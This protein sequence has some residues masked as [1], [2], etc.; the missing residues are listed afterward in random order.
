MNFNRRP[1]GTVAGAVA[2]IGSV[3][4]IGLPAAS[5]RAA[6]TTTTV[7]LP[8]STYS[9][10]V[11][12]PAH[13]HIF[14]SSAASNTIL[15]TNYSGQTV[16]TIT[17][18]PGADGLA[19]SSDGA[20]VYAA[21][22]T[23]DAISAIS[24][25][26]LAETARYATGTGTDPTYVAYTSGKVWFGYGTYGD[27]FQN[28]IGSI[29]PSTSPATVNL[30]A[31]NE[32][33]ALWYAAPILA[34][35]PNG[36]LVA[37]ETMVSGALNMVSFDT[38]SGGVATAL[39]YG[40]INGSGVESMQIT[41]DGK[42][43][44][45]ASGSPYY[46]QILQVSDMALVGEYPTAA[47]PVGVSIADDGTVAAGVGNGLSDEV[48]FFAPGGSTPLNTESFG[49]SDTLAADGVAITPDATEL[50]A[51]TTGGANPTLNI[52]TDPVQ[53][54][55]TLSLTAPA[56][57]RKH[58]P[59]T[60][61]GTLGGTSPY[62]GGQPLQVTRIDQAHPGGIALPGVTTAADGSFTITDTPPNFRGDSEKVTYKVSY[63]GDAHLTASTASAS[64]TVK[65]A[66]S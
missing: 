11:L 4:A 16:A 42:D 49:S 35:S 43:V 21:L 34:A 6:T 20:T 22:T 65:S 32:S 25:S 19:L 36:E 30:S 56:T 46:H 57:A 54:P 27:P 60:L 62:A 1:A 14:I 26:T 8:I 47:Y 51:V 64:V 9:H 58:H 28:G 13:Q 63:A 52:I 45:V 24:T 39:S 10:M 31:T 18:E 61:T 66:D 12:D 59:I 2:I 5:A 3:V 38:S 53:G 48:F 44:V 15:V 29:D 17:N 33:L 7:A 40:S 55:S 37:G 23:G 41:P 50:F